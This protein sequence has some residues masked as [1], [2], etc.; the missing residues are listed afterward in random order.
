MLDKKNKLMLWLTS[1]TII[2]SFIV[3]FLNRT[4]HL[5]DRVME[6]SDMGMTQQVPL[7]LLQRYF[8]Y[9]H[10]VAFSPFYII[11]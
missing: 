7:K 11:S 5:F 9:N 4:Y 10:R 8:E 3:H 2:L 6:A 1:G